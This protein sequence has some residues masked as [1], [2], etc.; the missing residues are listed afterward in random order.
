MNFEHKMYKQSFG[1]QSIRSSEKK[2]YAVEGK[3]NRLENV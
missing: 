2:S 1:R 3:T